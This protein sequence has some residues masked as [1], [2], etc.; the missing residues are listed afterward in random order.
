MSSM[1]SAD[2]KANKPP[3]LSGSEALAWGLIEAGV[4]YVTGHPGSPGSAVVDVLLRLNPPGMRIEWASNERTAFDAAFGYSLAGVRSLVC[5]KSVGLNVAL[6]SLMVSNLA[7]GDGGFVIL[8]GDDPGGWG[9]Q[10]EQDSRPLIAAA[11]I[12]MLEPSTPVE[13]RM[14]IQLAYELAERIKTPVAVRITQAM[15][16]DKQPVASPLI[17]SQSRAP[18]RF[19]RQ[20]DRW[21]V[22]PTFVVSYHQK[23]IETLQSVQ[24][25]FEDSALNLVEGEGRLGIIAPGYAYSKLKQVLDQNP[26]Q[27]ISILKLGTLHPLPE[28]RIAGFLKGL[29]RVLVIEETAPYLENQLAAVAFRAGWQVSISGRNSGHVPP[30]GELF[31]QDI[32]LALEAFLPT[33]TAPDNLEPPRRHMISADP[34]CEGCPYSP[35]FG[36]LLKVM[37][38]HGGREAFVVTGESGCMI[39]AQVSPERILDTKFA[40]GSSIGIASG[41]ARSGIP[42]KVISL[43]GDNAFLHTGWGQLMDA[44]QAGV[45][46]LVIILDN[47]TSAISGGQPHAAIGHDLR[48]NPR[49]AVNLVRLVQAA[50]VDNVRVVDPHNIQ[51]TQ[52]AYEEGLAAKGVSV[53][54][55]R[56]PC[57][58]FVSDIP[59]EIGT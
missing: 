45:N 23:L 54:I 42:Q 9:S 26:A 39:R 46:L 15:A 48:G 44:V 8:T 24:A 13:G 4:Q 11:E 27:T 31:P 38:R 20:E 51:E 21:T 35:G 47:A 19:Q 41:I 29:E 49:K 32:S 28:K 3:E 50:G 22:T 37:E 12:P 59:H 5:F 6:D 17:A 40:M 14:V 34:L 1:E 55:I 7:G 53:V 30:A 25:E 52:E 18:A 10:N 58:Y 56:H 43:A 33:W 16:I 57:P 36:S 2:P